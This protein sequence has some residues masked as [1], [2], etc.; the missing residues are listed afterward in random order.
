MDV[1]GWLLI[2]PDNVLGSALEALADP[3]ERF[4][5]DDAAPAIAVADA[6]VLGRVCEIALVC[7]PLD[8]LLGNHGGSELSDRPQQFELNDNRAPCYFVAW[9]S[10]RSYGQGDR[11]SGPQACH[12]PQLVEQA[13]TLGAL[14]EATVE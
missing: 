12:R 7:N 14:D 13:A 6:Y 2:D 1:R 8:H 10:G 11:P 3:I 5:S 4:E 9:F